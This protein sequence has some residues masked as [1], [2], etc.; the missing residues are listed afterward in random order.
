MKALIALLAISIFI[1][2]G[3]VVMFF[4]IAYL[5][6][7][8]V[9]LN[10]PYIF[11]LMFIFLISGYLITLL[12]IFFEKPIGNLSIFIFIFILL[13]HFLSELS[14]VLYIKYIAYS[15]YDKEV[16]PVLQTHMFSEFSDPHAQFE[17]DGKTFIWSFK[18][19]DFVFYF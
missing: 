18:E 8:Q 17:K 10:A 13:F 3:I 6:G 7:L 19:N 12:F 5:Y 16:H 1:C 11:I 15:K 9:L 14:M 4:I 2:L